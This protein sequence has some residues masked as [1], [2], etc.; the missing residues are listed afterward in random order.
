M[1]EDKKWEHIREVVDTYKNDQVVNTV[2]HGEDDLFSE[3]NKQKYHLDVPI[4][5]LSN[6]GCTPDGF[7]IRTIGMTRKDLPKFK[8]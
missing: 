3:E 6:G 7:L 8:Y 2:D 5:E 4:E 1:D